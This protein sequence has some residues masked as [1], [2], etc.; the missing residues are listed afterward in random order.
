MRGQLDDALQLLGTLCEQCEMPQ[1]R[2]DTES[3][4]EDYNNLLSYFQQGTDDESRQTMFGRFRQKA[5][6]TLQ[7]MRRSFYI[8]STN[9]LYAIIARNYESEWDKHLAQALANTSPT[10]EVQDD[11]FELLWTAPCL[12]PN[13]ERD[14]RLYLA[15]LS[16]NARY[17]FLC[18]FLLANLQFF[19]SA[20]YRLLLDYIDANEANERAVATV[21]VAF[22]SLIH[23]STLTLY[24]SLREDILW[25]L[26]CSDNAEVPPSRLCEDLCL[27]QRQFI[28]YKEARRIQQKMETEVL[29]GII[30]SQL[31]GNMDFNEAKG[32]SKN[33]KTI[34]IEMGDMMMQGVDINLN[35]FSSLKAFP[36][37]RRIGHWVA[38]FD[39]TRPETAGYEFLNAMHLCDS[40]RYSLCML[41]ERIEETHREK[42]KEMLKEKMK[43]VTVR[44]TEQQKKIHLV[45]NLFRLLRI[46]PWNAMWTPVFATR[47][48]LLDT[49]LL[50]R[51]LSRQPA[52]LLNIAELLLRY[53]HPE[54]A[55][56]HLEAYIRCAGATAQV[57]T[58]LGDSLHMQGQYP[59]AIRHYQQA[60]ILAPDDEA[61]LRRLQNCC[62]Q[63]G[64]FEEQ[65]SILQQLTEKH[66][67][68]ADLLRLTGNCLMQLERWEEAEKQFYHLQYNGQHIAASLRALGWCAFRKKDY[69]ASLQHYTRLLATP[70]K[71]NRWEDHLRMGHAL[72]LNG[73]IGDAARHYTQAVR[74]FLSSHPHSTRALAPLLAETSV[75]EEAGKN[76]TDIALMHDLV[77]RGL[78]D[79]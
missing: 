75:L 71:G 40:D 6:R 79:A 24:P 18:A 2:D 50:G 47:Q 34:I 48:I 57:L 30:K 45:Q 69:A 44:D 42:L 59:T 41:A 31:D 32:P 7:Q 26:P 65:L 11:I 78:N 8:R 53:R 49:P 3:V 15:T 13:E 19:D 4:K 5:H 67:E 1:Y 43:L 68:D 56:K 35:T 52:Y 60:L 58:R 9:T 29:P 70:V 66:P 37:F 25:Q 16:P 21:A 63:S 17:Y 28:L 10:P 38:P 23:S 36:F 64:R 61:L 12:T 39:T 76:S 74:G 33:V 46:S 51:H 54:P 77:Q 27:V 73:N 62:R 14:L 72:W 55:Q 20:K 22:A